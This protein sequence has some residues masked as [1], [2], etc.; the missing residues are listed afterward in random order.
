ML[1]LCGLLVWALFVAYCVVGV[2]ISSRMTREGKHGPPTGL[3]AF[4]RDSY[5]PEGQR[6]LSE[7][8]AFVIALPFVVLA[9]LFV[10][11][12]LCNLFK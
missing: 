10:S 4:R 1:R 5:T 9:I 8:W 3:A 2:R 12:I 7:M 6:L 11:T